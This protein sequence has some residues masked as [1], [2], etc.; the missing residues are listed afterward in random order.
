MDDEDIIDSD[1]DSF[2][3]DDDFHNNSCP[4]M[5]SIQS[6][7]LL[8]HKLMIPYHSFSKFMIGVKDQTDWAN[9]FL[10]SK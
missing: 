10:T 5:K 1:T 3:L 6:E 7:D 8:A 9:E 2:H 4:R